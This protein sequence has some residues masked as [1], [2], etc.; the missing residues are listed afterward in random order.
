MQVEVIRPDELDGSLRQ[1]WRALGGGDLRLASPYYAPEFTCAVGAVRSDVR[2]AV[3]RDG[4]RVAGFF[5]FQGRWGAGRPVAGRLSDHH[6]LVLE[7]G[8]TVDWHALLRACRLGYW[9]FD[10]L[11][12]GQQ[13]A[14]LAV[15]LAVSP[16][17]DLSAG[18][19]AWRRRRLDAGARRLGELPR[20][21]RKLAREVGPLRFEAHCRDLQV[22][23]TVMDW[24]SLQCRRTGVRDCFEPAWARALVETVAGIDGEAFA[25]RLST[26]HAGDTLVAAHFGMRS[27]R[28]WH[29]WFPVYSPAHAAYSPGSLLL[30]EVARAA[31]QDGHHL[32]DLGKGDEAYKS[33]FADAT[34]PLAEG[35]V[36]RACLATQARAWRQR[37]GGWA[38]STP[39]VQPVLPLLRRLGR[40]G[41]TWSVLPATLLLLNLEPG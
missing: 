39:L 1:R 29:W 21:A 3:L 24:K 8:F 25:G 17:L 14:G 34:L 40:I 26:L 10:H 13:P 18:F 4:G 41:S 7:P 22:L 5:A 32:L 23:R 19:E 33:S 16:G 6:G 38:R 35:L 15:R 36:Q 20:K 2:V 31:A 11:P 30:L 12:A 28:V 37:L 9:T 27:Q